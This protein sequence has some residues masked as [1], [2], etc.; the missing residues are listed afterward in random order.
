MGGYA[1]HIYG[2]QGLYNVRRGLRGGG[3]DFPQVFEIFSAKRGAGA[4]I[5][6][7]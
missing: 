7:L 2:E 5:V 1:T 3:R 6:K 4:P